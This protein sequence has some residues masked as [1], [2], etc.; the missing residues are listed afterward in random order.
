MLENN[1]KENLVLIKDLGYKFPNENSKQKRRYGLYKCFCGKEFEGNTYSI[2]K[3]KTKSC[4]CTKIN[5]NLANHRL[6]RIWKA[7]IYRCTN[8]KRK[9]YKD[10]G[11]RGITVCNKW[12]DDF[13]NFYN[14]ALSNGYKDD[15]TI[16]R[17]NSYGNYEPS[18]CRWATKTI[19]S[20]NTKILRKDNT[21]GYRGVS[22]FKYT[23]KWVVKIMINSKLLH[24]GYFKD[25]IDG[26]KAYD[27]YI[28]D[29]KLEHTKNFS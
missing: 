25:K 9:E 8:P 21:S 14:W 17:I 12:N 19:Q 13:M 6:Y 22:Y 15:L 11:L 29:N 4:G 2:K 20:R 23:N 10:Y 7:M 24:L 18:N 28:D 5:H 1:Q 3:G 27:Q 16:D 26:A